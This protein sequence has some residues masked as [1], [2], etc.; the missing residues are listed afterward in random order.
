ML[1]ASET[2]WLSYHC[3][4]LS[5]KEQMVAWYSVRGQAGFIVSE[6]VLLPAECKT[7]P[8]TGSTAIAPLLAWGRAWL[9]V[10]EL[11]GCQP[12]AGSLLVAAHPRGSCLQ[13]GLGVLHLFLSA[14]CS[15]WLWGSV[16]MVCGPL[17]SGCAVCSDQCS[18]KGSCAA[19][20]PGIAP[21]GVC[22]P[23]PSELCWV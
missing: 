14:G 3:E 13:E 7:L 11:S 16:R 10:P 18:S 22:V 21:G 1:C 15:F 2:L 12:S 8:W 19:N 4:L 5:N 23:K 17:W 20:L 9:A 6:G